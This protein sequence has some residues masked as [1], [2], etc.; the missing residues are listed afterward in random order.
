MPSTLDA[1]KFSC[2]DQISTGKITSLHLGPGP[3]SE[4]SVLGAKF[5]L[6]L[7][8]DDSIFILLGHTFAICMLP[9]T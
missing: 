9:V 6:S 3:T 5:H 4:R 2:D 8:K 1:V 7:W